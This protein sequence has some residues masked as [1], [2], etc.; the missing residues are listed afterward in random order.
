MGLTISAKL[1]DI[2]VTIEK[3]NSDVTIDE[4]MTIF[5]NITMSLGYHPISWKNLILEMADDI[6]ESDKGN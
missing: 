2:K 4:L 3:D 1:Y 6:K 5:E